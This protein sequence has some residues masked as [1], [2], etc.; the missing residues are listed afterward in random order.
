MAYLELHESIKSH[1]RKESKV[2]WHEGGGSSFALKEMLVY[3]GCGYWRDVERVLWY[4][5]GANPK[6]RKSNE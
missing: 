1:E 6:P 4:S 5:F 3:Y 2:V